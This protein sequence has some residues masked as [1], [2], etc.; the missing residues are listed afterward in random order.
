MD[1]LAEHH[2]YGDLPLDERSLDADPLAQFAQWLAEAEA[3]GVEEPNAMVLGTVDADSAP[4]SRTVLLRAVDARG[5]AF[6][7][8]YGSQKGRALAANPTATLLFPWYLLHRQVIVRGSV[9]T[10]D[11]AESDA[12]FASRPRGSQLAAIASHQSEPIRSRAELEHRVADLSIRLTAP[13]GTLLV[14]ERPSNWGGYVVAP[15]RIEF[16]KGRTSR[17][18]DRLVY[19]QRADARGWSLV[20]LQP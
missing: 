9:S 12:Y 19:M 14:A 1:S 18:H 7:S 11:A 5:F 13:D 10:L 6:Y 4:S 2:D 8:N 16:W 15:E 17:L 3:G 20:R